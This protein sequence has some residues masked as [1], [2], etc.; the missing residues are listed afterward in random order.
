MS[1][2]RPARKYVARRIGNTVAPGLPTAELRRKLE[3]A[4]RH[5]ALTE[6]LRNRA[7]GRRDA[8]ALELAGDGE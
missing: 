2:D 1:D 5:L 7:Q 6:A 8:I 3:A 4:E